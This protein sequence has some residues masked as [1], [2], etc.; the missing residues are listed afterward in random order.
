[1]N[2]KEIEEQEIGHQ[3]TKKQK[4]PETDHLLKLYNITI[5]EYGRGEDNNT[6]LIL[7]NYEIYISEM[8]ALLRSFSLYS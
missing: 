3:E 1:M 5:A 6:H 2:E 4:K 8:R 7:F